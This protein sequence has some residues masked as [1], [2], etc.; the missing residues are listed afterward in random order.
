M[1]IFLRGTPVDDDLVRT[2]SETTRAGDKVSVFISY[3]RRDAEAA[4]RLRLGLDEQGFEAYLDKHDI[5]PGEPWQE[6]LNKLIEAA[7]AV[8]FLISP[9]SA[10]SKVCG[11]EVNEAER[12]A[13]RILPVV[14][15]ATPADAIP[16]RLQRLGNIV[17]RTGPEA[18]GGFAELRAALLADVDWLREHTR[19]GELAADW[20]AHG[21]AAE[22][23]L[24]G[25]VLASAELWLTNR[26]NTG[27]EATPLQKAFIA[28]SRKAEL[29]DLATERD[30]LITSRRRL[31]ATSLLM[32]LMMVGMLAWVKQ[33]YLR[34]QYQWR[35]EMKPSVLTAKAEHD[36][37]AKPLEDF[38]ECAAG[39]PAMI[40]VPA[41]R[42]TMGQAEPDPSNP[43]EKHTV[44]RHAVVFARP[45]AISKFEVTFDEWDACAKAGA[46]PAADDVGR[47]RGKLPVVSVSWDEAKTYA[48]WLSKLTGQTYRLP[49]EAEWE[50]AA[51]GTIEAA[52]P[53]AIYP[54]GDKPVLGNAACRNCDPKWNGRGTAPVGTFKPN[55]FRLYDVAGNADEWVED[56]W[57]ETYD[58]APADGSPWTTGANLNL[59]VVRGGSWQDVL[60]SVPHTFARMVGNA[61][62]W[63]DDFY[64]RQ[65]NIGFRLARTLK[66][67]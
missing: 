10:A 20:E 13:K 28:G 53:A 31:G 57:H 22:R 26:P 6:R 30:R 54:W 40:V 51:R 64:V 32:L 63:R 27:L 45:F 58:G 66:S 52:A 25:S 18:A 46:C 61:M 50:Y 4:E 38:H 59:R 8:V 42:F 1:K 62:R 34:E 12:L 37:A 49:S 47:G 5:L 29:A 19:I 48:A 7:D 44:P 36:I 55:G 33:G 41:G 67:D 60:Q 43:L 17:M 21:N 23:L 2:S 24:Q 56:V 3:S 15:R 35:V 9:D 14:I 11:W 16:Q 39:C 65:Q